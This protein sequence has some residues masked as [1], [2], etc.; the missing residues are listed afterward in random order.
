LITAQGQRD[1]VSKSWDYKFAVII[2]K[3]LD[4]NISLR[5]NNGSGFGYT[6]RDEFNL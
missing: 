5:R 1:T 4:L 2:D 6:F 3:Y